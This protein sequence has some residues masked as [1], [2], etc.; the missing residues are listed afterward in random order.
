MLSM[1]S[2]PHADQSF[3][4]TVPVVVV[5]VVSVVEAVAS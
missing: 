3:T 1:Q 2:A 4:S 5:V